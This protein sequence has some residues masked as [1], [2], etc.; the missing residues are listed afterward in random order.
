MNFVDDASIQSS[1]EQNVADGQVTLD[2]VEEELKLEE[3]MPILGFQK[4]L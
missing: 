2:T 1:F 3:K 4:I